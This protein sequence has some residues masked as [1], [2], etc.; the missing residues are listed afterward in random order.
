MSK[1]LVNQKQV[2]HLGSKAHSQS[3]SINATGLEHIPINYPVTVS[4]SDLK[5]TH[6]NVLINQ[7]PC[8][9]QDSIFAQSHGD[10]LGT[11]GGIISQTISGKA[12][13]ISHNINATIDGKAIVT[14]NDLT[15]L[16]EANAPA[17]RIII[18]P[19]IS[20]S[21]HNLTI[22][23]KT[24][25]Q[26]PHYHLLVKCYGIGDDAYHGHLELTCDKTQTR[27]ISPIRASTKTKNTIAFT[28]LTKGLYKLTLTAINI[29][30]GTM[31]LTPSALMAYRHNQNHISIKLQAFRA[32]VN[33]QTIQNQDL[34]FFRLEK[35]L[36]L[37]AYQQYLKKQIFNKNSW[38]K[39]LPCP[40]KLKLTTTLARPYDKD[41]AHGYLSV[42][43]SKRLFV[44]IDLDHSLSQ[45][46]FLLP[47]EIN[48]QSASF[49][50]FYTHH[51]LTQKEIDNIDQCP[52]L[53][54]AYK[55]INL[56][57]FAL[58]TKAQEIHITDWSQY[59]KHVLNDLHYLF[60]IYKNIIGK[61]TCD[62][63]NATARYLN[64]CDLYNNQ[65]LLLRQIQIKLIKSAS[66]ILKNINKNYKN[67][68]H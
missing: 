19:D 21:K 7:Y 11:G 28:P 20:C 22:E 44:T 53:Y 3:I 36:R 58:T 13:I 31:C 4:Q 8:A 17:S 37:E 46:S 5:N 60:D 30:R 14:E 27:F 6:P 55:R 66:L 67:K 33:Q 50:L 35:T 16:N 29:Q 62:M 18:A 1:V 39:P 61:S 38:L 23:T 57:A 42:F 41:K 52:Y 15:F 25:K 49:H 32:L 47:N 10:R 34:D 12:N 48:G 40:L 63:T 56:R 64:Q 24:Q 54:S 43:Y 68:Q 51:P 45:P 65:L 9:T 2:L 26:K 59:L